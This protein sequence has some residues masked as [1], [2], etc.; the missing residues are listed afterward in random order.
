VPSK[1]Q[2]AS[3]SA[4]QP[5]DAVPGD[6]TVGVPQYFIYVAEFSSIDFGAG[7]KFVLGWWK[8]LN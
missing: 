6:E 8:A 4:H 5:N 3:A 2:G 1:K 7:Y